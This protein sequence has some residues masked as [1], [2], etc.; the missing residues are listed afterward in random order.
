[1]P[2][3][4]GN[5][6][7]TISSNIRE[8]IAA[9][10]PHAQAVAAAL[11]NARYHSRGFSPRHYDDGGMIPQQGPDINSM[12]NGQVP[13]SGLSNISIPRT[14]Q[15]MGPPRAPQPVQSSTPDWE[16]YLQS[17][18]FKNAPHLE[19]GGMPSSTEMAPWYVRQAENNMVH[20]SGL[21]HSAVPG[22]T[23]QLNKMVPA[24]AYVVPADVVSGLGEGNTM[25]GANVMQRALGTGPGG[26][27]IPHIGAHMG[28]PRAPAMPKKMRPF[29][30]GG[31][32]EAHV[33][34]VLAG[35]EFVIHPDDVRRIGGG[36][37]KKG[38]RI[39]DAFVVHAR[40][41]TIS[42]MKNLPGPKK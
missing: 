37:I 17:D 14:T 7:K 34:V 12:I 33:P 6:Q 18:A 5:S 31:A 16:K 19:A 36:N 20:N 21:L 24:G 4:P 1:M 26:V 39:L 28:P 40:K 27:P 22:R 41:Q 35:G 30:R 9:G 32:S 11:N 15:N 38:H 42:Q 23:D 10:H 25:A 8:M 2:L 29:A 3:K 13:S